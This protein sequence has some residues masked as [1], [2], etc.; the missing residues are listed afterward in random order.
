MTSIEILKVALIKFIPILMVSAKLA[1]P[2]LL[3]RAA[4]S[5][6]RLCHHLLMEQ[7]DFILLVKYVLFCHKTEIFTQRIIFQRKSFQKRKTIWRDLNF[8][9]IYFLYDSWSMFIFYMQN[10]RDIKNNSFIKWLGRKE[11]NLKS[12][13]LLQTN[14]TLFG[15]TYLSNSVLL[16]FQQLNK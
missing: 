9:N 15:K 1:A 12:K 7:P 11:L 10:C 5:G 8:W 16:L 6:K 13:K 2:G 14:V 4:F 3:K